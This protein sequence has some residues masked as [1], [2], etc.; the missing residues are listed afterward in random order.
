MNSIVRTG[1]GG[2]RRGLG[3]ARRLDLSTAQHAVIAA[4][5]FTRGVLADWG[6][7]EPVGSDAVLAVCE[8]VA[9]AAQHA[10]GPR[11]LRLH[12]SKT[13]LRIELSDPDPAAPTPRPP[14]IGRPGGYGLIVLQRLCHLWGS[15]PRS[16]GKTVWAE[17]LLSP[18]A[19]G[20][21]RVPVPAHQPR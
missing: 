2:A 18:P 10:G 9:N 17:I 4:R 8:L 20:R 7:G 3:D 19:P 15:D 11:T 21:F 13:A 12:H 5:D 6:L 1:T 16:T 14:G